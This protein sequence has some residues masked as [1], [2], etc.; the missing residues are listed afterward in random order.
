MLR[1]SFW[2][3]EENHPLPLS[4]SRSN[5][6]PERKSNRLSRRSNHFTQ[7]TV[8]FQFEPEPTISSYERTIRCESS[9]RA[10]KS[11]LDIL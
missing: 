8:M 7:Q 5:K 6:S 4:C 10:R 1:Q 2:R 11:L 9:Q 3:D